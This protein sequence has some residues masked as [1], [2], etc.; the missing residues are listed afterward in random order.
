MSFGQ[1]V[2]Q[3]GQFLNLLLGRWRIFTIELECD[4]SS[5]HLILALHSEI[6]SELNSDSYPSSLRGKQ[7]EDSDRPDLP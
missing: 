3:A 2:P 6:I 7:V 5:I 1:T 4:V